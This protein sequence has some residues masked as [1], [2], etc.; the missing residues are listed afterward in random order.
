MDSEEWN[1]SF[2]EHHTI[3][4]VKDNVISGFG[5]IDESGYLDRL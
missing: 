5:D 3:A 2:L 4:A 1:R